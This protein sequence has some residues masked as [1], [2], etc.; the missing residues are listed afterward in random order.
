[1]LRWERGEKLREV[2][3]ED[4][5]PGDW[6]VQ[7]QWLYFYISHNGNSKYTMSIEPFI[8]IYCLAKLYWF[9]ALVDVWCLDSSLHNTTTFIESHIPKMR[10]SSTRV[11]AQSMGLHVHCAWDQGDMNNN[12]MRDTKVFTLYFCT[13]VWGQVKNYPAVFFYTFYNYPKPSMTFSFQPNKPDINDSQN[14]FTQFNEKQTENVDYS[15]HWMDG[16][17]AASSMLALALDC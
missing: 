10:N 16:S 5:Y 13:S 3:W 8:L 14:M 1:M 6:C 9:W 7:R 4:L 12:K 17:V 15:D 2:H 11:T